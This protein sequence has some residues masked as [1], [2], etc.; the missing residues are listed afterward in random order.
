MYSNKHSLLK[1]RYL[2]LIPVPF[3]SFFFHQEDQI[4]APS[5]HKWP[6]PSFKHKKHN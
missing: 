5:L 1:R 6:N 4:P 3:F 2:L